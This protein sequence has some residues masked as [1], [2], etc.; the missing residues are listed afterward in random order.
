MEPTI[1]L[2]VEKFKEI[3]LHSWHLLPPEKKQELIS[4]SNLSE[5]MLLLCDLPGLAIG[6]NV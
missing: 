3:L 1:T 2:S 5:M 4:L 6:G